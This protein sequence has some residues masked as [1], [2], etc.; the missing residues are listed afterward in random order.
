MA[1]CDV[2]SLYTNI[3][4][5]AEIDVVRNAISLNNVFTD[6]EQCLVID[7]LDFVLC[8]NYFLFESQFFQQTS[9]TALGCNVAPTFSVMYMNDFESRF[10]YTHPLF[11]HV[12]TWLR[13]KYYIFIVWQGSQDQLVEFHHDINQATTSISLSLEHSPLSIAFLDVLFKI[14][15]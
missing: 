13:Y 6:N 9:G 15:D 8:N 14:T 1:T 12:R 10:V 3:P 4:T 5:K 11:K 7:L 2:S